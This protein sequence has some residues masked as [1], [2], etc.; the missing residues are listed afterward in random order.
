MWKNIL[1]GTAIIAILTAILA[2]LGITL[3]NQTLKGSFVDQLDDD[4]IM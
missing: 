3:T 1:K 2:A 4:D